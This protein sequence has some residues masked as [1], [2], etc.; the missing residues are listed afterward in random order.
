LKQSCVGSPCT[1]W[2]VVKPPWFLQNKASVIFFCDNLWEGLAQ[3]L[4]EVQ[5]R[6]VSFTPFVCPGNR[7]Q[8]LPTV[9]GASFFFRWYPPPPPPH[10]PPPPPFPPSPFFFYPPAFAPPA[11]WLPFSRS[12]FNFF[13]RFSSG[14]FFVYAPPPPFDHPLYALTAFL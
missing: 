13:S 1:V 12:T 9:V 11:V 7:R 4:G 8:K 2:A 3:F 10:P 5:F 14:R 6:Y